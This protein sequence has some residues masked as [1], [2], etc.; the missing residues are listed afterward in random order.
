MRITVMGA[1]ELPGVRG[2]AR[3]FV[4]LAVFDVVFNWRRLTKSSEG[5]QRKDGSEK[6]RKIK[7]D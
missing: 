3:I 5:Q 6:H 4:G 2:H 7:G 1:P